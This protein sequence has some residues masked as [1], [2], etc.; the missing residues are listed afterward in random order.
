MVAEACIAAAQDGID[1]SVYDIDNDGYVDNVCVI[2]AGK[3]AAERTNENAKE[4]LV[5]PICD[6]L[7]TKDSYCLTKQETGCSTRTS[8]TDNPKAELHV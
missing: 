8:T 3:N 4:K 2:F 6:N 5:W 1:F 7:T